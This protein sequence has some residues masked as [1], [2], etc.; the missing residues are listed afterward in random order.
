MRSKTNP[1]MFGQLYVR[2]LWSLRSISIR[3]RPHT[4]Q[5][6]ESCLRINNLSLMPALCLAAA[7]PMTEMNTR[8]AY[9]ESRKVTHAFQAVTAADNQAQPTRWCFTNMSS[10]HAWPVSPCRL[11][12]SPLPLPLQSMKYANG[13]SGQQ[14]VTRQHFGA[15][16]WRHGDSAATCEQTW[17]LRMGT[18][19]LWLASTANRRK[20]APPAQQ[21]FHPRW[22]LSNHTDTFHY[23]TTIV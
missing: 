11:D 6:D 13:R 8:V 22:Y 18:G 10:H 7:L 2:V 20:V 19:G 3:L 5:H 23:F 17:S 15:R 21:R 9:A 4:L 16:P 12:P 14:L 1:S